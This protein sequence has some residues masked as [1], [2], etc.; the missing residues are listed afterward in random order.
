MRKVTYRNDIGYDGI[1]KCIQSC[2][3]LEIGPAFCTSTFLLEAYAR[4]PYTLSEH[5]RQPLNRP[6]SSSSPQ[7]CICLLDATMASPACC[8]R[9]LLVLGM[10]AP[11]RQSALPAPSSASAA[12]TRLGPAAAA[13]EMQPL[14]LDASRS[15]ADTDLS[16]A[17]PT[18]KRALAKLDAAAASGSV[19][20][21][22]SP[23]AIASPARF[24]SRAAEASAE[25][26][27][28][29][30]ASSGPAAADNKCS[31]ASSRLAA[32][33]ASV[34]ASSAVHRMARHARSPM[35]GACQAS[36]YLGCTSAGRVAQRVPTRSEDLICTS[37]NL[38]GG[39]SAGRAARPT[40]VRDE[41]CVV[42]D[43]QKGQLQTTITSGTVRNAWF[44]YG[45]K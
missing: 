19:A 38:V 22:Q 23:A 20:Q 7:S 4:I 21:G 15:S 1:N 44:L 24:S 35:R 9:E 29:Q 45:T 28:D 37:A 5:P 18:G 12:A 3:S 30:A 43:T 10:A 32:E 39:T 41:R 40:G 34:A 31:E 13:S 26:A 11:C 33:P 17:S 25:P 42:R 8:K 36:A 16:S 2:P 14:T 27:A 6:S